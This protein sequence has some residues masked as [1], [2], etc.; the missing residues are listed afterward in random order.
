MKENATLD[1]FG[2]LRLSATIAG[3]VRLSAERVETADVA[4]G[5]WAAP[6]ELTPG[7]G[8]TDPGERPLAGALTL[9]PDVWK[10]RIP[11]GVPT[12]VGPS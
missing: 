8:S 10:A 9:G 4:G 1:T 12:P 7:A 3:R 6:G 5:A 2:R 11:F